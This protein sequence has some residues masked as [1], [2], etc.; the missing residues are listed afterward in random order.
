MKHIVII[1]LI[2][3]FVRFFIA[4]QQHPAFDLSSDDYYYFLNSK[5]FFYFGDFVHYNGGTETDKIGIF[6][7]P[8]FLY[9]II[10]SFVFYFQNPLIAAKLFNSLLLN[11]IL[12]PVF[13]ILKRYNR[14]KDAILFSS[15]VLFFPHFNFIGFWYT[16]ILV[17]PV[18]ILFLWLIYKIK[19]LLQAIVIFPVFMLLIFYS[20]PQFLTLSIAFA[21]AIVSLWIIT[22]VKYSKAITNLSY[23]VIFL[24]SLILLRY[25]AIYVYDF[26]FLKYEYLWGYYAGHA[27]GILNYKFSTLEPEFLK[28]HLTY[29]IDQ[30]SVIL[31]LIFFPIIFSI[32]YG[33][34]IFKNKKI[35][36][37]NLL[38]LTIMI[39]FFFVVVLNLI[40]NYGK[41][42][43]TLGD[44]SLN[45]YY[46]RYFLIAEITILFIG[47]TVV[48]K[49]REQRPYILT[50][51]FLL[52]GYLFYN[53]LFV[54][55]PDFPKR[56][57]FMAGITSI[58]I[59]LFQTFM[60]YYPY[61]ILSFLVLGL[62][63]YFQFSKKE[64]RLLV[65]KRIFA[66]GFI[67]FWVLNQFAFSINYRKLSEIDSTYQNFKEGIPPVKPL[68]LNNG[69]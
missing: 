47:F 4:L 31:T 18:S 41:L 25:T 67:L 69:P 30:W 20:R 38:W 29:L 61:Q 35:Y 1:Y 16:E 24:V 10:V 21:L 37:L 49:N 45:L 54:M 17:I 68:F 23:S 13:D 56:S 63:L 36:G 40:S 9:Q 12:F 15:A 64:D 60:K 33:F 19:N 55:N 6:T 22:K 44:V 8:N 53:N 66:Y 34:K 28:S 62:F 7:G 14:R 2:A 11:S 3:S 27:H 32:T 26:I 50:L 39:N 5:G 65:T 51:V 46:S 59:S 57:F 42:P 58:E 48:N 43:R 52:A